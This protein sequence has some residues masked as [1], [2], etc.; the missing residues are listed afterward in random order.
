MT[1][2]EKLVAIMCKYKEKEWWKPQDIM[3]VEDQSLFVGYEASARLSEL[4][5]DYPQ[6]IATK[7]EGRFYLRKMRLETGKE[8]FSTVPKNLQGIIRKYYRRP[9]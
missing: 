7:K 6:M 8:W 5:S 4:A 3:N 9:E 2:Q 1:Q